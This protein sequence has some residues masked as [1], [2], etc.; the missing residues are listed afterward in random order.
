MA[1]FRERERLEALRQR[2]YERGNPAV[3]PVRRTTLEPTAPVD[4]AR[5]WST[6]VALAPAP[7]ATTSVA[8]PAEVPAEAPGAATPSP[9]RRYRIVIVGVSFA[10]FVFLMSI[11]SLYVLFGGN[12]ISGRNIDFSVSGPNVVA[13]GDILKFEVFVTNNN[14]VAIEGATLVV[15]YPAGARSVEENPRDLFE[16]RI[17]LDSIEP[18][19]S[20]TIPLQAA[21]FGE[22]NQEKE[23]LV[24]I[25]Y[26][27]TGS[28]GTFFK[29]ADP[30][31]FTVNTS[32]IVLRVESLEQVTPG[33][34]FAVN[35]VV[36]SNAQ[37]PVSDIL[38]T[39]TYP[40][41]FRFVRAEPA[42]DFRN[43]QWVIEDLTSTRRQVITIRGVPSGVSNESFT[44]GIQAGTPRS[45][46]QFVVGS[47]LAQSEA[48]FTVEQ[49]FVR[50]GI[51]T[52]GRKGDTIVLPTGS[53]TDFVLTV[54]NTRP[55]PVYDMKV[56]VLP[57]GSAFR[58]ARLRVTDGFYDSVQKEIRFEP[59]GMASLGRVLPGERREFRFQLSGDTEQTTAS[60]VVEVSVFA[61][62]VDED[63]VAEELIGATKTTV[64]YASTP[65]M[66]RQINQIS[67]PVPP[68]AN[69]ETIYQLSLEAG[70]GANDLTGATVVT[71]LP[72]YVRWLDT[73]EGPGTVTYNPVNRELRWSVG[74][75]KGR[76]SAVLGVRV[77][78]TPSV[79]QVGNSP[80]MMGR[81]ELTATDRFTGSPVQAE[82]P[83][84]T[85]EMS[86]ESGYDAENGV[87]LAE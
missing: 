6:E 54:E 83:P 44:I 81:Q 55:E 58:E 67:G 17:P 69:Q 59:S 51:E 68:V 79:L 85:T 49:P 75:I 3:T 15:N 60:V 20:R 33:Q 42:P 9:S 16:E 37:T 36:E 45:D 28:N 10:V 71:T 66:R 2:L 52:N 64:Q 73:Y 30:L 65:T 4:V 72:Q 18:G 12:Q 50:V 38:V 1:D 87:V 43:N 35:L 31:V 61:R 53:E 41:A 29:A 40:E 63:N 80:V 34:E 86:P 24:S 82:A 77:G 39:A 62:R 13:G 7:A 47:V 84:I 14:E 76:A 46:N 22:E 19:Q 74:E 5:G 56:T 27:V 25:D 8:L 48:V 21:V 11:S 57:R 26:R 70:A 23:V 32:P 78:I